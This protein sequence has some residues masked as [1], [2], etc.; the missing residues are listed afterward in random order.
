[1]KPLLVVSVQLRI[2]QNTCNMSQ[3]PSGP[4]AVSPASGSSES[5]FGNVKSKELELQRKRARDRKS[6]QAMR[7]RTKWTIAN[8]TEQVSFLTQTLDERTRDV[9]LLDA[10]LRMLETD[11]AHL[12]AQN[13]ALQLSL[14]GST[15]VHSPTET[16]ALPTKPRDIWEMAPMNSPASCIADQILQGFLDSKR[17]ECV[18]VAEHG[19]SVTSAYPLKPNLASLLHKDRRTDDDISNVVGDIVRSYLEIDTLPKQVAVFYVMSTL[20]KVSPSFMLSRDYITRTEFSSGLSF[21]TKKAG[22][23]CLLGCDQHQVNCQLHMPPGLIEFR[24]PRLANTWFLIRRLHWMTGQ[25]RTAQVYQ[26]VGRTTH[27]TL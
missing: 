22:T 11:N 24:G 9:G 16:I 3:A 7:D 26:L 6:Q 19:S 1:M 18:M 17:G 13:A 14:I 8:L 23:R 15:A 25:P 5:S 2:V 27:P 21:L 4:S 12:R 10:R 20:L